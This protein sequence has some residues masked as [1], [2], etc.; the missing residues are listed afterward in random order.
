MR[1]DGEVLQ[2]TSGV[3][4]QEVTDKTNKTLLRFCLLGQETWSSSPGPAGR[5]GQVT[6]PSRGHVAG[7][8]LDAKGQRQE[9]SGQKTAN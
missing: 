3:E 9:E 2:Q 7:R 4:S 1:T 8:L 6:F 5:R